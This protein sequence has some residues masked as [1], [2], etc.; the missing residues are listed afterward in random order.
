MTHPQTLPQRA[1]SPDTRCSARDHLSAPGND[2]IQK[3]TSRMSS[4]KR[5]KLYSCKLFYGLALLIS[6][7]ARRGTAAATQTG[8]R[9]ACS[10]LSL[11]RCTLTSCKNSFSGRK[12]REIRPCCCAVRP[13]FSTKE[14]VLQRLFLE[15]F[16]SWTICSAPQRKAEDATHLLL[17]IY[18]RCEVSSCC[19]WLH[20]NVHWLV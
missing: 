11:S 3:H 8:I 10:V 13:H 15:H 17:I 2:R 5:R 1:L 7:E 18:P 9:A 4:L 6:A 20:A 12:R 14:I 16:F 19:I